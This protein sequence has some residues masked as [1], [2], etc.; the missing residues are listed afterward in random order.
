[1]LDEGGHRVTQRLRPRAS[2]NPTE[3]DVERRRSRRYRTARADIV[4]AVGG[5]VP[6]D[7]AS[8]MQLLTTHERRSSSTTTRPA[9]TPRSPRN[10]PPM[11]AIPTTA[12]TGSEVGRF[13]VVTLTR[14]RPEDGHLRPLLMPKAAIL[15]PELTVEHARAITAATGFDALTH[16]LEAYSRP[17]ITRWPTRSRSRASSS[18]RA[19]PRAR[20]DA[21]ATTSRR[22]AA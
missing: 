11:I 20:G 4:I 2:R 13:G 16:C 15:D 8:S 5:G 18:W 3:K 6:L 7:A 12:G 1:M 14:H 19:A 9:A 17:A 21:T 22:A 10:V